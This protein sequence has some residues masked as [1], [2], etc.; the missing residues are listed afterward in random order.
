MNIIKVSELPTW[1]RGE[2]YANFTE[3]Y[4]EC[5]IIR[6]VKT[7][8]SFHS[9]RDVMQII[10]TC[11]YT[12]VD[13]MPREVF[14][15]VCEHRANILEEMNLLEN[16][17]GELALQYYEFTKTDEYKALR[18][19]SECPYTRFS[20]YIYSALKND[21]IPL[22]QYCTE[23]EDSYRVYYYLLICIKNN[24]LRCFKY[25]LAKNPE[26]LPYIQQNKSYCWEAAANGSLEMLSYLHEIGV[27]WNQSVYT[28]ACFYFHY[29]C[30]I[31]A[32]KNG[33][34]LPEKACYF[35]I[36]ENSL[37]LL[38]LLVE[39]RKMCIKNADIFN[40]ALSKG[41]MAII[42]YL[43]SAGS[44][45]NERIVYYAIESGNY[46]CISFAIQLHHERI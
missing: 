16:N 11:L 24:R 38:K 21:N 34:P 3:N 12:G 35:A 46:E 33:C 7:D 43:Y 2:M 45:Q 17:I 26:F 23:E 25:L 27:I 36:N 15:F 37:E 10:D 31:Y 4:G 14:D 44:L 18:I 30:A 8:L 39:V 40:Y 1:L 19:C 9:L 5:Q 13:K 29:D 20:D 42:H 32:L 28:I 41:N 22:L 6:P